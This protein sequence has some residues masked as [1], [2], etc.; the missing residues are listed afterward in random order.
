R[1]GQAEQPADLVEG[2]PRGVV[3]GLAE[4][5]DVGGDVP[6]LEQAGVAAGDDE[7]DEV[8]GERPVD[9]RVDGDV[10]DDVVHPV[11]RPVQGERERLGRGD[12]DG[13]R[14]DEAGAGGDGEGVDVGEAA[15]GGV[16]G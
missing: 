4:L 11:Q 6:H 8:V 7:A 16:E 1:V 9:E 12:A 14:A 15:A 2:L 3:E 10:P 13:E 5:D